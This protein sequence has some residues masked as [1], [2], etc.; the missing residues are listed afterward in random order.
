MNDSTTGFIAIWLIHLDD[1]FKFVITFFA[2][3]IL[4]GL[5]KYLNN[6]PR[7]EDVSARYLYASLRV[8]FLFLYQ[9]TAYLLS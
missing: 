4:V 2:G 3:A 8:S 5:P 7:D 6:L 9:Q 1:L